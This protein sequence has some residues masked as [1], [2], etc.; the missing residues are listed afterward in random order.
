MRNTEKYFFTFLILIF[1]SIIDLS[2]QNMKMHRVLKTPG[3]L[4]YTNTSAT[5]ETYNAVIAKLGN[6][7]SNVNYKIYNTLNDELGQTHY[8]VQMYFNNV[9]VTL[10][11]GI[12][13][14]KDNFIF[15][16]NGDFILAKDLLGKKVLN[17]D[18]A[19]ELAFKFL[20]SEKYYWQDIGMNEILQKVT[21]NKDTTYYPKGSLS[22]IGKN[23]RL[24]TI[25]SLCYKFDVFSQIPLAG[26]SIYVNA[27][28]GEIWATN[29][30]ILHTEVTGKATT[31]YS[32]VRTIKTDS[33]APGAYRLRETF[34]GSGIETYNLKK[35]STYGSAVDFMDADNNW[36]NVNANKDEVAT[37]AH[38]GAEQTYD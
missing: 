28:T 24:D 35:T 30:L 25:Q 37:D 29:E 18:Q 32:G 16:I 22:Y 20:P 33:T 23:N 11:T 9:P 13:H 6:Y 1:T 14:V 15:R 2:A 10:A 31:K 4:E 19:R 34:R 8:R 36:N 21:K 27:E 26:K 12:V 7:P 38:W 17:V 3:F 5:F